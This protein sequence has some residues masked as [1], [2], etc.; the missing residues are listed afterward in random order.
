V[1]RARG[2]AVRRAPAPRQPRRVSGPV[3]RPVPVPGRPRPTTPVTASHAVGATLRAL[4]DHRLLDTLLR[5]RAWIW[6]LGIALGG[7]VFMQV[8]LLQ[9]NSGIGSAVAESTELEHRNALLSEQVAELS[10]GERIRAEADRLGLVSPD[11]G[12]VGFL[13]VRGT[14]DATRA[15]GNMTPPSDTARAALATGGQVTTAA[16]PEETAISPVETVAPVATAA[17]VETAAPAVT[18]AAT[19]APVSTPAATAAPVTTP[20]AT[21]APPTDYAGAT[22]AP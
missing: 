20:A 6:L 21:A 2:A 22:A 14:L 16:V 11:A 9:M 10:S 17:P 13:D 12:A 4:P 3:A 7:I 8:S 19:A 15:L 5:S 1:S 18:P